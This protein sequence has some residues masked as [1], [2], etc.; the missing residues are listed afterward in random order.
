M[1][2]KK[3]EHVFFDLDHTLWDFE[4]NSHAT[5]KHILELNKDLFPLEISYHD[6]YSKYYVWNNYYWDLFVKNKIEREVLRVIRF[7]KTLL[8]FQIINTKL[9]NRLAHDYLDL[10][11]NQKELM[12]HALDVLEYLETR[13]Q[14][15]II[16]N[17][18]ERVQLKKIK[19]SSIEKYFT[20]IISSEAAQA[21][22]PDRK[23]FDYAFNI[24][25]AN[26]L[27][28]IYIG[29][30]IEADVKGAINSNLDYIFFNPNK[31]ISEMEHDNEIHSLH[32]I[33]NIL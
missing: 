24:S 30:S 13:Y 20:H 19:N 7:E 25:G 2:K 8:D 22:K 1:M 12:P 23:I 15:H 4:T 6:F 27:N 10:L 3:Y 9:A 26:A 28:S 16:T 31:S 29:D 21:S 32:E 33:K 18:F 11:P 5:L 14:I 17:G